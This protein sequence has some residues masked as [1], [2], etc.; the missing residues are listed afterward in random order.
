M[1]G[2]DSRS[3]PPYLTEEINFKRPEMFVRVFIDDSM[4][5]RLWV[6]HPDCRGF[7]DNIITAFGTKIPTAT[8][9]LFPKPPGMRIRLVASCTG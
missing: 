7:V 8:Q 5:E 3:N 4:G 9:S 2:L 1:K 6:D